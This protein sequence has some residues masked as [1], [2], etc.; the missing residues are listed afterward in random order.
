M[1]LIFVVCAEADRQRVEPTLQRLRAQGHRLWVAG[2]D[3]DWRYGAAQGLGEVKA[4]VAFLSSAS[5]GAA[6]RLPLGAWTLLPHLPNEALAG[7]L[8]GSPEG[9]APAGAKPPQP[10]AVRAALSAAVHEA[11]KGWSLYEALAAMAGAKF[12]GVLIDANLSHDGLPEALQPLQLIDLPLAADREPMGG[13]GLGAAAR[14]RG[15]R[16]L[17]RAVRHRLSRSQESLSLGAALGEA[18]RERERAVAG[19]A[20]VA[21][22]CGLLGWAA[23]ALGLNALVGGAGRGD[24][25]DAELEPLR[26]EV[27]ALQNTVF[28]IEARARL[29]EQVEARQGALL[30]VL[31]ANIYDPAMCQQGARL[32]PL[33]LRESSHEL[34]LGARAPDGGKPIFGHGDGLYSIARKVYGPRAG[35]NAN[36]IF[37]A[38]L[39]AFCAA[40][41][42]DHIRT[43]TL[44]APRLSEVLNGL[45]P[46]QTARPRAEAQGSSA[47]P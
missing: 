1:G 37:F 30:F 45:L 10:P 15:E 29:A 38:N 44:L 31:S 27:Q 41:G 2:P 36:L 40:G 22:L 5:L 8:N 9:F 19:I 35:P 6:A 47:S 4:V 32:A 17:L 43:N 23:G 26:E 11:E 25:R 28:E 24:S 7:L 16:A 13:R 46:P 12:I 42:P 33:R 20:A 18:P 34:R 39:E 14:S 21:A 3:L